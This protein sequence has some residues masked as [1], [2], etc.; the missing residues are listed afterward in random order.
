MPDAEDVGEHAVSEDG[1]CELHALLSLEVHQSVADGDQGVRPGQGLVLVPPPLHN[2]AHVETQ[3]ECH[4]L[5]HTTQILVKVPATIDTLYNEEDLLRIRKPL[6]EFS[7]INSKTLLLCRVRRIGFIP[8]EAVV[9][10]R[11][12]PAVRKLAI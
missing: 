9:L 1:L 6:A 8:W 5:A 2:V 3:Q 10:P 7:L 12:K 4:L 11:V